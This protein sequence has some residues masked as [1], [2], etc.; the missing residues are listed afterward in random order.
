MGTRTRALLRRRRRRAF[1]G[2][3]KRGIGIAL[4]MRRIFGCFRKRRVCVFRR[5]IIVE[6][7]SIKDFADYTDWFVKIFLICVIFDKSL[8]GSGLS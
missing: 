4:S 8:I 3:R 1:L 5:F 6:K 2:T 7:K